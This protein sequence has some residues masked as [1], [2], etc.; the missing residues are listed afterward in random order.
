MW[1]TAG[2]A[3]LIGV[4]DGDSIWLT[5][6]LLSV[7]S[8]LLLGVCAAAYL[9][10]ARY[11]NWLTTAE[12]LQLTRVFRVAFGGLFLAAAL[13][14]YLLVKAPLLAVTSTSLFLLA[15]VPILLTRRRP[16]SEY[17]DAPNVEKLDLD[18]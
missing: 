18:Q 13:L 2:S 1:S 10:A 4:L 9:A 11:F 15:L 6:T 17:P 12:R 8:V 5:S 3:P 14:P 7:A 16:A